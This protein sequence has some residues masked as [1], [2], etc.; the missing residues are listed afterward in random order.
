MR[1]YLSTLFFLLISNLGYSQKL[2]LNDLKYIYEH[3]IEL[4]DTYLIKKGFDFYKREN[5]KN[6]ECPASFYIGKNKTYIS[7]QCDEPNKGM[8]WYQIYDSKI[9]NSI[10]EECKKNGY[11]FLKTWTSE[12]EGHSL[13]YEYTNRK[14]TITFSSNFE[15]NTTKY[16]IS[17]TKVY[18]HEL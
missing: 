4:A 1:I 18:P 13:Y 8:S 15:K 10:K 11:K 9:Y 12:L 16:F 5:E 2:N 14:T 6:N 17:Y 7:K 3:D